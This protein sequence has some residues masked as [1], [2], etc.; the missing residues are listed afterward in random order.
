HLHLLLESQPCPDADQT[1]ARLVQAFATTSLEQILPPDVPVHRVVVYG[2]VPNRTN[3][4]WTRSFHLQ[5]PASSTPASSTRVNPDPA[6]PGELDQADLTA[7]T[8]HLSATLSSYGIA[9][10]VRRLDSLPAASRLVISCEAP[11]SPNS[12]LL[13]EPIAQRLRELELHG[14]QDA[15]VLGQVQGEAKPDWFLRIDLTPPEQILREWARWGDVQAITRLLNRAL[16]PQQ[17]HLSALLKETTLHLTCQGLQPALPDQTATIATITPVLDSLIPQGLHSVTVYGVDESL[18]TSPLWVDW[19]TLPTTPPTLELARRGDLEAIA[20]LLTRLLNPDLDAKL[21]TGG[22]RVQIVQKGDVLHVM[23][24]APTC[25]QQSVVGPSVARCLQPLQIA[26]IAGVRVYGRRAGQKQ[27]LWSYGA[28][29]VP[30]QRLVPE[31]TPEF[32]ASAAYVG[33]LLTPAGALVLRSDLPESASWLRSGWEKGVQHFRQSLLKSRLFAPLDTSAAPATTETVQH[34][35][36]DRG[37]LT[38]LV[39]TTVGVLLIVQVDWILGRVLETAPPAATP[40]VPVAPV[41]LSPVPSPLSSLSP[42]PSPTSSLQK[43]PNEATPFSSSGFTRKGTETAGS[44]LPASPPQP[45][46]STIAAQVPNDYPTFNSRQLDEKLMLYRRFLTE[47]GRPD[48]LIIGSS[49]ALRGIDPVA[50]QAG[51]ADRGYKNATVFNFGINGATAQ[52]ADLILRQILPQEALPRLVILADG[53]RAFNGN[54][55]DPTFDGIVA[56]QGY[57]TL[58]AGKPPIPGT[59]LSN[60]QIAKTTPKADSLAP[61]A[62]SPSANRYQ[63]TERALNHLLESASLSYPRRDRLKTLIHDQLVSWLPVDR[64][65][66]APESAIVRQFSDTTSPAASAAN[67]PPPVLPN[68]LE[69]IDVHGFL[70][71][72][73]RFNPAT[74]YQKYARVPGDYDSDYESFT[75]EGKQTVALTNL[76]Q[77]TQSRQIPLV[78]VGLPLTSAY[79]DPVRKRY[80]E[81]FQQF[82]V[83]QATQLKF[84]YRDLSQEWMTQSDYFSDPSHLNRY[85]GYKMARRLAEDVMI[86]W[87]E[88]RPTKPQP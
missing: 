45:P 6:N 58:V 29:F 69:P 8:H 19:L 55:I 82:M 54:R 26:T 39:W 35:S 15:I 70:A 74:Y 57:R 17:V 81:Q 84:V 7:I 63:E 37:A 1:V 33:D 72:P 85:G 13:A 52:V 9:I 12:T 36:T 86:P 53:A 21:T 31:V 24:D 42:A 49:R 51:L 44:M 2:R 64:A 59:L 60:V 47:H 4:E 3:P 65:G 25:P 34:A 20:F 16:Q 38:A 50:L 87:S 80:E 68:G 78:V 27:P 62:S 5:P 61:G 75:L 77:F 10:K 22:T 18:S 76:V 73:N 14:F 41:A 67:S 79:L 40:Q 56:S 88:I 28:D 46:A 23:T 48:V 32:A 83:Q 71:L 66:T 43:Q 30:R 11:Y